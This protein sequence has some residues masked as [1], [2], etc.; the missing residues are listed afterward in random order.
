MQATKSLFASKTFWANMT[1]ILAAV[2]GW[3]TG[4]VSMQ[5]ALTAIGPAAYNI[6]LRYVT[7][8]PVTLT[9][10]PIAT[11]PPPGPITEAAL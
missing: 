6:G 2:G 4:E 3:A 5:V 7:V 1:A 9:G 8:A 11:P 10:T